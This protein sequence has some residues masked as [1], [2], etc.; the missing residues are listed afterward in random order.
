M[1]PCTPIEGIWFLRKFFALCFKKILCSKSHK[2]KQ[3][4]DL[5][6]S[7]A[8]LNTLNKVSLCQQHFGEVPSCRMSV[9]LQAN[10]C[11][12]LT[13]DLHIIKWSFSL[14]VES[15]PIVEHFS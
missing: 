10:L 15:Y 4:R 2:T 8:E 1:R 12:S 3:L 6:N 9:R 13:R 7:R 5:C 14:W 11:N